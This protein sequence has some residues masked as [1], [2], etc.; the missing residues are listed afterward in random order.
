MLTVMADETVE[1]KLARYEHVI[2]AQ[3]TRIAEL[4]AEIERLRAE[5]GAHA[6]LKS[7]YL[8][9]DAPQS[10]RAKAAGLALQHEVPKLQSVPPA[11]D[12]TCEEIEYEPLADLVARQR[13]RADRMQREARDIEVLPSGLVRVLPKPGDKGS[14][15]GNDS[16][17]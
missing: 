17:G 8:D 4:S 11:I 7:I 6:A 16:D 3:M 15:S 1:E 2:G 10:L 12:A 9:P 13:A 14:G 5:G